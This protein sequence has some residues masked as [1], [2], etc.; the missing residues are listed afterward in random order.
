MESEVVYA[1]DNEP[2]NKQIVNYI[3]RLISK[4]C[5]VCIWPPNVREKDINDMIYTRTS[6][7]IKKIIDE[8]TYAGLEARLHFRNWRKV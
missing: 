8:N 7:E 4:G 2:R 5:N 6:K 1:L 3:D